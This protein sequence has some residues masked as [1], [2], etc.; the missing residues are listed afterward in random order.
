[1][2]SH[3]TLL[4]RQERIA[5]H[6]QLIEDPQE[7]LAFIQDRVRKRAPFSAERR[8]D[9]LR[10]P[11]CTTKVWLHCTSQGGLCIFEVDSESSMVRGLAALISDVYSGAYAEEIAAFNCTVTTVLNL[12]RFVSPTRLHG[13]D[14][15]QETIRTHARSLL[16]A[17][18]SAAEA[19]GSR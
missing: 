4:Q 15:L 5:A 19:Q 7:R 18:P 14:R 9:A 13:L 6:L 10:V 12:D 3:E 2:A 17:Q 11:G 16:A 1:M 8:I